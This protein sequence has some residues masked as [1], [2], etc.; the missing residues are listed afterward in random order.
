MRVGAFVTTLNRPLCLRSTLALL[1]SQTRPPDHVV[2]VDN[3][4]SIETR[5]VVSAFPAP[6]RP[7]YSD[8]DTPA[9]AA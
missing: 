2:V 5:R 4:K 3:G 8:E 9:K 7:K 1:Q 6:F